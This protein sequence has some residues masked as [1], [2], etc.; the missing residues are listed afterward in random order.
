MLFCYKF[1]FAQPVLTA[2]DGNAPQH[3]ARSPH[4][5]EPV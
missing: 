3:V 1:T 2:S 4:I 5:L